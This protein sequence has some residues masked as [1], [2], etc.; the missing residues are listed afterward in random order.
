MINIWVSVGMGIRWNV[1]K[2]D[3]V[4]EWMRM[5]VCCVWCGVIVWVIWVE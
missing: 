1:Y 3:R 4:G 5:I 2:N